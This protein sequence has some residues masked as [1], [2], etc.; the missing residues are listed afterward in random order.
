MAPAAIL[1]FQN[2][3]ILGVE[4]S[5][6][7]K[8]IT[9]PNFAAI[10]QAVAEIWRFLDLRWWP[11][12]SWIFKIWEFYGWDRKVKRVKMCHLSLIHI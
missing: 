12:P 10:G 4:G 5:R 9:V 6:R 3:K 8:C 11:P 7:S 2:V 1:D